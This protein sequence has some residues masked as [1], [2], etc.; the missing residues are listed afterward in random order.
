MMSKIFDLIKAE[1]AMTL[2]T[3]Q[4][5]IALLLTFGVNLTND[6]QGSIIAFLSLLIALITRSQVTPNHVVA[7]KVS[8]ALNT[9]VPPK[10][11]DSPM[12]QL[13]P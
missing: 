11:E 13:K 5:G 7:E 6:Q 8:V 12:D 2:G 9:P 10:S 3:I 1:P 4:A